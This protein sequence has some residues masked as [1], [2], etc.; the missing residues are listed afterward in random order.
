MNLMH[1]AIVVIKV[2]IDSDP[3]GSINRHRWSTF[4]TDVDALRES[5]PRPLG[6]QQGVARLAENVWLVNFQENPAALAR[7]VSYADQH[8]FPYGI[9]QLEDEP[10]WL[11]AGFDPKTK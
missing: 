1:S 8:Q 9:L 7:L 3:A 6:K 4:I 11:P 10:Q 2:Q 5:T